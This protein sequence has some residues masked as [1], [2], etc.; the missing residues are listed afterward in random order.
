MDDVR[1]SFLDVPIDAE[2]AARDP[3]YRAQ[4]LGEEWRDDAEDTDWEEIF[5]TTE[6]AEE[7]MDYAFDSRD[8]ATEEEAMTALKRMIHE[9][10]EEGL[11][12]AAAYK[13][14]MSRP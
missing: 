11:R 4:I 13:R 5:A 10:V 7:A 2:R 8:Y 12:D 6:E 1:N 9:A 3:E 14:D